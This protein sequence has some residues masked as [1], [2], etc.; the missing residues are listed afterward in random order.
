[1]PAVVVVC[2]EALVD[3][4]PHRPREGP[5]PHADTASE[6]DG[7]PGAPGSW[8]A[9]PGGSPANVAVGLARLGQP[10][11]L[12]ARLAEDSFGRLL[13]DHL[14][15]AG[16]DLALALPSAEPTT[17]AV[18]ALDPAGVADYSFYVEGAADGGWHPDQLPAELPADA[19]AVMASGSLAL[20]VPDFDETVVALL[21]RE[22]GRRAV[23]VDPNVRLSLIRDRADHLHRLH[24]WICLADL[25]KV[26]DAD[27][28]S[29]EP[30]VDPVAVAHRWR[31]RGPA[32]VVVT[33]G[34]QGAVAV[35]RNDE[36]AVPGLAVDVADTVGA[37][38]AFSAG[39]LTALAERGRLSPAGLAGLTAPDLEQVLTF[40]TSVAALTCT[41]PG[42]DP[43]T[44]AELH[45]LGIGPVSTRH[46]VL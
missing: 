32:V 38:D 37:G 30:G 46:P 5:A 11:T 14:T 29:L 28:Q 8:L 34:E 23:V 22:R 3:L 35:T 36:I 41:R 42:A 24:R 12:L 45:Q 16:V 15:R 18:V 25:V 27:L 7:S 13:R 33:R 19:D 40:A 10:A 21:T 4:M 44:R 9:S 1:V 20:A 39:L 6:P 17:L 2:G 26:S 31:E 43:P